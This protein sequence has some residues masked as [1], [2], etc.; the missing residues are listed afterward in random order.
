MTAY[1]TFEDMNN[2][3]ETGTTSSRSSRDH[4]VF[5][6][7]DLQFGFEVFYHPRVCEAIRRL[8][9]GGIDALLQWPMEPDPKV[10]TK[11]ID[12]A[13]DDETKNFFQ[14]DYNPNP[15]VV[16]DVAAGNLPLETL[17]FST[18]GKTAYSLYNWE[19]FFYAPLLIAE[20]LS[21]NQRFAEA[22]ICFHYVFD[23]TDRSQYP[24]PIR[25]W[26]MRGLYDA[27][28]GKPP[29]LQDLIDNGKKLN[30]EVHTWMQQPFD[31][32][33]IARLRLVA[34]LK[35]V[36]MKYLDNIIAW[37]D[38][39]FN[40]NTIESIN[41]A[42]Q[43][44]ILAAD[45]LGERPASITAPKG[46]A[47]TLTFNTLLGSLEKDGNALNDPLVNIENLLPQHA[48]PYTSDETGQTVVTSVASHSRYFCL[49]PNDKLLSYWDTVADRLFKIRHC[50]NI[51][52][53]VQ[54]LPL[55][56]PP[57]NP[58]LLV[59]AAAAGVDLSSALADVNVALP[60]YRFGTLAQKAVELCNDV[61]SLGASLLA[62]LEKKDAEA[63]SLMRSRHEIDL[64]KAVRQVKVL[65]RQEANDT[66]NS[67]NNQKSVVQARMGYYK[68]LLGTGNEKGQQARLSPGEQTQLDNTKQGQDLTWGQVGT[69]IAAA[70]LHLIPDAKGGSPATIGLTYGGSNLA[71]ALQAFGST[72]GLHAQI[73]NSQGSASSIQAGYL[74]RSEEWAQQLTLATRELAQV[75][76]QILAA[77]VRVQIAEKELEN[78]DKQ[79]DQAQE[80]ASFL[81]E[82][83]TNEDL[84]DWMIGQISAVYFQSYQMAY[85]L[86]KRAEK[87]YR[88]DRGD[89]DALFINFGYWDSLKQGLLAGEKLY[90]DLKRMELAYLDQNKR[91]FEITKHIS[92]AML[93]PEALVQLR[94]N[95][96][97]F[98]TLGEEIFDAD[99]PGHY[100]RRIKTVAVSIPCITGP[101][102]SVNCTLTLL[103][104]KVRTST[105][106]GDDNPNHSNPFRT[107]IGAVQAIVTSNGLN[108]TGLFETSLHEERLLPFEGAG[109]ISTWRL[110]LPTDTNT[111]KRETLTDVVI[112]MRYTARD[113]GDQLRND[114]RSKLS[115]PP[116]TQLSGPLL[117]VKK[118]RLFSAAHDFA[119]AW[120]AFLHQADD[121]TPQT[122]KLDL[123]PDQF[124][125]PPPENQITINQVLVLLRLSDDL[126]PEPHTKEIE[127][128]VA[129]PSKSVTP[130]K[131]PLESNE[132][133]YGGMLNA[134]FGVAGPVSG[135]WSVE[136]SGIKPNTLGARKGTTR[137]DNAKIADLGLVFIFE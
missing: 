135:E 102:D 98:V 124:P 9:Q 25:F 90:F 88:Y 27:F 129:S 50:M 68:N 119:D 77:T 133:V 112:Q 82:K 62:A 34:C 10:P 5:V 71:P 96:Q 45:I 64:L 55:F 126:K 23:P 30:D 14:R 104:N 118:G 35:F 69:E 46:S 38:W 18:E 36:M 15:D 61:K 52:G 125:E 57:I 103:S 127:L 89:Y 54:Q 29:T 56:E 122:L 43:L 26:R 115:L 49:P 24:S 44:Y 67:V 70:I 81:H 7:T 2:E 33:A 130:V 132:H 123:T 47:D 78:H 32:W 39:H 66:L 42:T 51:Q 16:P 65:Q 8:N 137:L 31:P 59:Q 63:L 99:Y 87:A 73:L 40:A 136:V 6:P 109:V 117:P 134:T 86:A 131:L 74:R 19:L 85:S 17:D 80:I 72:L 113:A 21:Q 116:Y 76:N 92:L 22:Q 79:A 106:V 60:Q 58:A 53:V 84:Y 95:G 48:N 12:L 3:Y 108:D 13:G 94:E 110:E 37:G 97:C 20:R 41:E 111:F 75:D 105:V 114:R 93:D 1:R 100:M 107:N 83:F 121:G 11:P 28:S 120:Y 4:N 91:E 101:H 128:T